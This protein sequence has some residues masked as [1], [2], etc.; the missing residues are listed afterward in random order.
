MAQNSDGGRMALKAL[1]LTCTQ[2]DGIDSVE[3]YVDGRRYDAGE[4]GVPSFMNVADAI[5]YDAI[6]SQAS[7]IF[8]E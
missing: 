7:A 2:F 5:V 1:V 6:Q 3:I 4:L 8:D